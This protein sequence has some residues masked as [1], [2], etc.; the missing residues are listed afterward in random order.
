MIGNF[1]PIRIYATSTWILNHN[2]LNC[3]CMLMHLANYLRNASVDPKH[4]NLMSDEM[5]CATPAAFINKHLEEIPLN[6]LVCPL[7]HANAKQK[8]CPDP[9]TCFV[10]TYDSTVVFNC[11]NAN[12]STI[13]R[14]P[15]IKQL[16]L[17]H[18]ELYI[19]N[20]N[21]TELPSANTTGYKS[22]NRIF[23]KNNS[24]DNIFPAQLPND[25]FDLDLCGNQLH[26]MN[27]DVL[28][29]LSHMPN[30]QNVSFGRNPWI[31]DCDAYELLHFIENNFA[32]VIGIEEITCENDISRTL[33]NE[34]GLCPVD[35]TI[36]LII[37]IAAIV[38]FLLLA[39]TLYY[40]NKQ[41]IMVWMFAHHGFSWLFKNKLNDEYIYDAFI[42]YASDDADFVL[43]Q[44]V[45]PIESG[46]KP[47]KLCLLERELK[48]GDIVP[49]EVSTIRFYALFYIL[50]HKTPV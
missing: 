14:L 37:L 46:S 50:V 39:T 9:C 22:V 23:A 25:L 34:H 32:R 7:D 26:R 10:R 30:L 6:D 28:L 27:P 43:K 3:D 36:V 44:L 18:Y 31:C 19:E 24:I 35:A 17:K 47:M 45:P 12:L 8:H 1:A 33:I 11:S 16:G 21:I 40:K 29:K 38:A 42:L 48:G 15:D 2:P 13:P 20:N 4:L 49:L 41:E 5:T